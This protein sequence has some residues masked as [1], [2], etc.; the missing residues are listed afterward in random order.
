MFETREFGELFCGKVKFFRRLRQ[1]HPESEII[2]LRENFESGLTIALSRSLDD[3][4]FAPLRLNRRGPNFMSRSVKLL[5]QEGK[6]R[7]I[8]F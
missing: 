2:D 6:K 7:I 3:D 8:T 5:A 4:D 1:T